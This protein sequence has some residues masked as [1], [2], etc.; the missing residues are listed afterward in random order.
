LDDETD[1]HDKLVKGERG[2]RDGQLDLP[3]KQ[4]GEETAGRGRKGHGM[5]WKE[6][7]KHFISYTFFFHAK[8]KAKLIY[9]K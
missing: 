4:R 3:R 6:T 8:F 9:E 7:A 5:E 2:R 1:K